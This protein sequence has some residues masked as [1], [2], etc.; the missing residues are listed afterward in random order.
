MVFAAGFLATG[1]KADTSRDIRETDLSRKADYIFMEAIAKSA[2]EN[3]SAEYFELLQG[4]YDL[5]STDTS[6]GQTLGY[7]YMVLAD[8]DSVLADKGYRMMRRH[9]DAEPEDYYGTILYGMINN[10]L[11]NRK[12]AIRVWSVADSLFPDKPDVGVKLVD[13]LQ[14]SRDSASL[15]RS[16]EILERIERAEGKD[17]GLTSHKIRAYNELRDTA[18]MLRELD[19][20]MASSPRNVQYQIY[21]GD[22]NMSLGNSDQA[23]KYYDMACVTD[24]TLGYAYYKRSQYYLQKGDSASYE[25]EISRAIRQPD[26]DLEAKTELLRDYV[27]KLYADSLRQPQIRQLFEEVIAQQPHES[28]LRDLYASYLIIVNDMRGAIEQEEYAVDGDPSNPQRWTGILS[29]YVQLKDYDNAIR[30]GRRGLEFVKDDPNLFLMTGAA[31]GLSEQYDSARVYY[32]EALS[33]VPEADLQTRSQLISSIGD[34]YYG[35]N[36]PDS[37][38]VYYQEAIRLD[39]ENLLALNNFAYHLAEADQDLDLAERYSAICVRANPDNDTSVDTYAWVFYK[40]KDYVKAKEWIDHALELQNEDPNYEIYDH[41][42]DIYFMNREV[43]KAVDFWKK[44]SE[45]APDNDIIKKK[46]KQ[47]TPFVE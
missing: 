25:R 26:L 6:V 14:D 39:P 38:F 31:F 4:A 9:F 2:D 29:L 33:F 30:A 22:I 27:G 12:E 21:A 23:I 28:T 8:T 13:A 1:K 18:A 5:D 36:L 41:A 43:S 11:G 17:L 32:R 19:A 3:S 45:L 7:Y 20:L 47:R 37:A 42:G 46:I 15:V 10:S 35:Q 24:S 40:K 44:A 34:T 16:L